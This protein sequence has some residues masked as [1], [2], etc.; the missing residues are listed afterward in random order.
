MKWVESVLTYFVRNTWAQVEEA[1]CWCSRLHRRALPL[2]SPWYQRNQDGDS[3]A[4]DSEYYVGRYSTPYLRHR[5]RDIH[6]NGEKMGMRCGM[7]HGFDGTCWGQEDDTMRC[8]T[9]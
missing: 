7:D 1:A 9:I 6:R 8:D 4:G 2:H 5:S 3:P